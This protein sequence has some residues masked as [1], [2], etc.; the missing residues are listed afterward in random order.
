[1]HAHPTRDTH[2]TQWHS[3][4]S[5]C[6]DRLGDTPALAPTPLLELSSIRLM[7]ACSVEMLAS[8]IVRAASGA[9]ARTSRPRTAISST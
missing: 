4:L 3:T 6:N 2:S 7:S 8:T 5:C 1:M 9:R